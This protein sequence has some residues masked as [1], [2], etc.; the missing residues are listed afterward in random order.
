[1]TVSPP[2]KILALV[3]ILAALGVFL[4]MQMSGG[5]SSPGAA[6][7]IQPLHPVKAHITT[8][9]PTTATK[10][11]TVTK[12]TA[13][14]KS[15]T[16]V[17]VQPKAKP[18]AKAAVVAAVAPPTPANGL[19]ARVNEALR[20][21]PVVVVSLYNPQASVDSTSLNE[22]AAGAKKAKVGFLAINVLDQSQASPFTD[23]FGVLQDPTLL[24]YARP[25]TLT[26]KVDG[27]ADRDVVAQA[28]L[29]AK[30]TT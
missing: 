18:K 17:T 10:K 25:G 8:L 28:A 3:G 30:K 20:A 2:I 16:H 5:S 29:S 15:V 4:F 22:A 7:V 9:R 21:Y 14:K 11:V 1:M 24:I 27:F 6:K 19:P 13:G 23:A 12:V 26:F